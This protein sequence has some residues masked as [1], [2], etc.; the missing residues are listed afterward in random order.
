MKAVPGFLLFVVL[1]AAIGFAVAEW[2]GD[3]SDG[4][5]ANGVFLT[6]DA[7]DVPPYAAELLGRLKTVHTAEAL[8]AA[9]DS[10]TRVVVYDCSASSLLD[11][12]FLSLNLPYGYSLFGINVDREDLRSPKGC[13]RDPSSPPFFRFEHAAPAD[14]GN[15]SCSGGGGARFNEGRLFTGMLERDLRMN[16]HCTF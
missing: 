10:G 3:G 8:K 12:S 5:Y 16:G 14:N 6:V 2:G 15:G 4:I 7:P 11:D 9:I 13:T 1:L